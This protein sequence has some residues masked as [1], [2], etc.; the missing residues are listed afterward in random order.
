MEFSAF[1]E[2]VEK[3]KAEHPIWFKGEREVPA[4]ESELRQF[5]KHCA[6]ALPAAFRQF[7]LNHGFGHFGFVSVL[8]IRAGEASILQPA[9]YLGEL[10]HRYLPVSENG[11]GDFYAFEIKNGA[12]SETLYFLDHEQAYAA[13]PTRFRNFLAFVAEKGLRRCEQ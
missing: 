11:C 7:A 9:K 12:C 6:C 4:T 5:E 10:A 13:V 1:S 8:S 2:C 3:A